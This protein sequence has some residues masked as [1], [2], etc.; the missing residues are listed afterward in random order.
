M[1]T[2]RLH[3]IFWCFAVGLLAFI[4]L[5]FWSAR[6]APLFR[7]LE[8]QWAEDVQLL[9]ASKK[10]PQGWFDVREVE[11]IGGTP[12]TKGILQ[13]IKVPVAVK[14]KEG[15]HKLEVLVVVWEE[16]GKRGSLIQYNLVN[17]KT[18]NMIWELGRTLIL[19]KPKDPNL[20]KAFLEDLRQ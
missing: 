14:K 17:L 16:E 8:T 6:N 4:V 12:E 11:I 19:S 15:Q 2:N 13:R 5:N 20:F 9:E 7:R 3:L 10:L 1:L 18:G